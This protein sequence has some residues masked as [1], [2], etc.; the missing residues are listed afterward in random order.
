MTRMDPARIKLQDAIAAIDAF[1]A[2]D[3][4]SYVDPIELNLLSKF[5]YHL[6]AMLHSID[7]AADGAAMPD[8]GMGR[9]IVDHWPRPEN[10]R[11]DV[12]L[13]AVVR[14]VSEADYAYHR[15]MK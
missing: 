3:D 14:K 2:T 5:R 8:S 1:V 6:V 4:I 15:A 13:N 7:G 9:A 11:V 10:S 12:E